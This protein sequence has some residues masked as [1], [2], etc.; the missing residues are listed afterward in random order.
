M[1]DKD[2]FR[3]LLG[4]DVTPIPKEKRV[5][6]NKSPNDAQTLAHRREV[7]QNEV[8]PA[9]DPVVSE[10]VEMVDPL[11]ELSFRLT[12]VQ[13]GVFR[14]LRQGKYTLDARLDLH[15]MHVEQVRREVYQFY[16]RLSGAGRAHRPHYPRQG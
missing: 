9:Q 16:P 8:S 10:P 2:Q 7:A 15:K 6:I 4:D 1:S 5:T 12:G 11:A 13:H 14:N 3:H